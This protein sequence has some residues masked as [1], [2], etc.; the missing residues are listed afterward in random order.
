MWILEEVWL[1]TGIVDTG[2]KITTG[3]AGNYAGVVDTA[4]QTCVANLLRILEEIRNNA[5]GIISCLGEADSCTEKLKKNR[6]T[7]SL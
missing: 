4:C 7:L 5:K 6:V 3:F 2:G 1:S